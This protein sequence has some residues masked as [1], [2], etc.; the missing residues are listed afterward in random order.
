MKTHRPNIALV[1][2]CISMYHLFYI[3]RVAVVVVEVVLHIIIIVVIVEVVVEVV[4]VVVVVVV[5]ALEVV[6]I[7]ASRLYAVMES[8]R[9]DDF[10]N[11]KFKSE[12]KHK[13]Q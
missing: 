8:S 2:F 10:K 6:I 4:P 7:V 5:L 11:F 13:G 9:T 1:Y 12:V 3:V